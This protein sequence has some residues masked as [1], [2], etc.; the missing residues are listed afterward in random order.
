MFRPYLVESNDCIHIDSRL[1]I[2]IAFV[3]GFIKHQKI[4]HGFD[5]SVATVDIVT[6]S[7]PACG[8]AEPMGVIGGL[9]APTLSTGSARVHQGVEHG[10]WQGVQHRFRTPDDL[11]PNDPQRLL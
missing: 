4:S 8:L 6:G 1:A 11:C 10:V 5:P 9:E 7:A 2:N 3:R